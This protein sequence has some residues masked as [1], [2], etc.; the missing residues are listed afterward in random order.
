MPSY[1]IKGKRYTYS[2]PSP[3]SSKRTIVRTDAPAPKGYTVKTQ[4][5]IGGEIT[6]TTPDGK[7]T[8]IPGALPR[9]NYYFGPRTQPIKTFAITQKD[10]KQFVSKLVEEGYSQQEAELMERAR[11]N[12][13]LKQRLEAQQQPG[14]MDIS[15]ILAQQKIHKQ[16]ELTE[17]AAQDVSQQATIVESKQASV[18]EKVAVFNEKYSGK[19]L[20]KNEY[21][22]A[23]KEQA[24]LQKEI[25]SLEREH[26]RFETLQAQYTSRA[27][28]AKTEI[29]KTETKL[30]K[31]R[32][33]QEMLEVISKAKPVADVGAT[34][35]VD[36]K[37]PIQV[38]QKIKTERVPSAVTIEAQKRGK[39]ESYVPKGSGQPLDVLFP[40][41]SAMVATQRLLEPDPSRRLTAK[42]KYTG[43]ERSKIE[44]G[45][46][47]T[48][49]YVMLSPLVGKALGTGA[50]AIGATKVGRK[51]ITGV[52]GTQTAKFLAK[53]L[54]P[55]ITYSRY[56]P[57]KEERI[58]EGGKQLIA[59][60]GKILYEQKGV[61]A[62]LLKQKPVK[63]FVGVTYKF[64]VE[65]LYSTVGKVGR[66]FPKGAPESLVG[67]IPEEKILELFR[68]QTMTTAAL[69]GR[70]G[71]KTEGLIGFK[72][73]GAKVT[74]Y[75]IVSDRAGA[76]TSKVRVRTAPAD[77]LSLKGV[78]TTGQFKLKTTGER[79]VGGKVKFASFGDDAVRFIQKLKLEKGPKLEVKA[80]TFKG[81]IEPVLGKVDS[82]KL[83]AIEFAAK[84][85]EKGIASKGVQIQKPA[86]VASKEILTLRKQILD[87]PT[88]KVK[89][90]M[91]QYSSELTKLG[92]LQKKGKWAYVPQ[93]TTL[94][95]PQ[96]K[97]IFKRIGVEPSRS[98]LITTG[99]TIVKP[100]VKQMTK[101]EL[102]SLKTTV[103]P[104]VS[105][106]AKKYLDVYGLQS[107]MKVSKKLASGVGV[108][109]EMVVSPQYAPGEIPTMEVKIP[110][111]KIAQDTRVDS[112]TLL[113][114]IQPVKSV[115]LTRLD[116]KMVE[117]M[118]QYVPTK[119]ISVQKYAEAVVQKVVTPVKTQQ[120]VKQITQFKTMVIPK[121]M[122]KTIMP[123]QIMPSIT[124]VFKPPIV[125]PPLMLDFPSFGVAKKKLRRLEAFDVLIKKKGKFIKIGTKL[126][127][128][129]ATLLGARIAKQ[130]SVRTFK[131][132]P[133]GFVAGKDIGRVSL[134][135]F[136]AP[137]GR[138]KLPR[139]RV[140]VERSKYAIDAPI[141]KLEIP[142]A[143]KRKRKFKKR[144]R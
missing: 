70:V 3:P 111:T 46:A 130:T 118:K 23:V 10:A 144:K 142:G 85:T 20:S 115:Q 94:A 141:E 88:A 135:Q 16:V 60:K 55:T 53:T 77:V 42:L 79:L 15:T 33:R 9:K 139:G 22:E 103:S 92:Q 26:A 83:R 98:Q 89:G 136:R 50:K 13:T 24:E 47:E 17:R 90:V 8:T 116:Q 143:T 109:V 57:I 107:H 117:L 2:T 67:L 75:K 1:V 72:A 37:M 106:T 27:M 101:V 6:T 32:E 61:I 82:P 134:K 129:I 14:G 43:A 25:S 51:I 31:Q 71:F 104:Q 126:P 76:F 38:S 36:T 127:E 41:S 74:E 102:T 59:G 58:I 28:I 29:S 108:G 132:D 39:I 4:K 95:K 137:K 121:T 62:K 5:T 66:K 133:A 11:T 81:K 80:A 45:I 56:S 73:P 63:K 65:E 34:K 52:S 123:M 87:Y 18:N 48:A 91:K 30:S 114:T 93:K 68:K 125:P 78:Q 100:V 110:M 54:K 112:K 124:P 138:T 97:K 49:G 64:N 120:V 40:V 86:A 119:T 21:A 7:V 12:V 131:L 99:Q 105:T 35:V 44:L 140:Y 122:L 113:K 69:K 84:E 128:N 96:I 19:Q